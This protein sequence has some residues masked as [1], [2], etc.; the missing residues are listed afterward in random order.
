MTL[1]DCQLYHKAM[2]VELDET[3]IFRAKRAPRWLTREER[4]A[5]SLLKR[6]GVRVPV[7]M[8]VFGCSKNT[9]YYKR[10][11]SRLTGE[12]LDVTAETAALIRD[13]GVDEAWRQFITPAMIEGVNRENKLEAARRAAAFERRRAARDPR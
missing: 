2:T 8:R 3:L 5:I 12:K 1:L 4:V 6:K 11:S 9:I 7:L 13:I 10:L